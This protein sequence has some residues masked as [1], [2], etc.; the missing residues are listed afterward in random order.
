[1]ILSKKWWAAGWAVLF[2]VLALTASPLHAQGDGR[3]CVSAFND[4][5]GNSLRDS[6]EPLLADV[7]A[8]LYNDQGIVIANY[9]TTGV[10]EPHCFEGLSAGTYTVGFGGGLVQPTGQETFPVTLVAGQLVPVQVLYGAQPVAASSL[11]PQA[12]LPDQT[13]GGG[14]GTNDVVR[15]VL[16]LGGAGA[17]MVLMAGLGVVIYM[18]RYRRD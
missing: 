15:F 5:N 14:G 1:M 8:S 6:I 17:I 10:S 9:V 7:V 16:A 13:G 11:A 2:V 3:V 18:V 12:V 4:A